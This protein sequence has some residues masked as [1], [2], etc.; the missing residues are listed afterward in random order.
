MLLQVFPKDVRL[1]EQCPYYFLQKENSMEKSAVEKS[2]VEK[3]A[4]EKKCHQKKC[5]G[6]KSRGKKCHGKI[7]ME[8]KVPWKKV[9]GISYFL[10][11]F[12]FLPGA[13]FFSR[14]KNTFPRDFLC[15]SETRA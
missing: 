10:R 7:A 6:K 3:S 4:A 11:G 1:K 8:K 14:V 9:M 12:D 13:K 5:R 2:T 15:P